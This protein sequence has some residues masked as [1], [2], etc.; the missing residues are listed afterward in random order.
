MVQNLWWAAG[1]NIFA[2]PLAAGDVGLRAFAGDRRDPDVPQYRDRRDQR[3]A[4]A[5][6]PVVNGYTGSRR[7]YPLT[8][9][10]QGRED[11]VD[12]SSGNLRTDSADFR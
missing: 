4:A 7:N 10:F 9:S 1:Y 2:I 8:T 5:A 12:R 3:A 6:G 11:A